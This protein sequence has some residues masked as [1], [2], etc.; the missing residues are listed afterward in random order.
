MKRL[1]PVA[2]LS[3]LTL[4]GCVNTS[5]Y[6]GD[7][8]SG[9]QAKSSQNVT[10]GTIQAVRPVQIQ[11]DSRTGGLLGGG[12]GALIG[13]VL[14]NQVGG[15]SGRKIATAAGAIGG[16]MAGTKVEDSANRIN[17]VEL[18]I[19]TDA[20]NDVVVVQKADRQFEPGQ[21]VRLIGSGSNVSVAPY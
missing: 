6:S 21:K 11:A 9:S 12:T 16:A 7:V 5:P 8:Y 19:R 18:E 15:G 13:G 3:L 17:G 4:A 1:L 2:A 20:G 10:Y 14:G